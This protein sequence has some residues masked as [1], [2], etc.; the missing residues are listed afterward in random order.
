[1]FMVSFGVDASF[2]NNSKTCWGHSWKFLVLLY[3]LSDLLMHTGGK[4]HYTKILGLFLSFSVPVQLCLLLWSLLSNLRVS[5]TVLEL[6]IE[7]LQILS[8]VANWAH[9]EQICPNP[10]GVPFFSVLHLFILYNSFSF[11]LLAL[12]SIWFNS[13]KIC[14]ISWHLDSFFYT[15]TGWIYVLEMALKIYAF[16]FENYWR[17]GQN[18]FDF[19]V[20]MI[21]GNWIWMIHSL[22]VIFDY[23][24]FFKHITWR[25][26]KSV[27]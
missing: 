25:I 1:M 7:T 2:Y 9:N 12:C 22:L 13:S 11:Y 21:I 17:D 16:G 24:L 5:G 23:N 27:S 10:L 18:R 4:K 20:T 19:L 6:V 26:I 8:A 3:S 14:L 15:P